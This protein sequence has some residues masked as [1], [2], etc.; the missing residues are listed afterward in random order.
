[1]RYMTKLPEIV[2]IEPDAAHK[3]S[4]IIKPL[5]MKKRCLIVTDEN[6]KKIAGNSVFESLTNYDASICVQNSTEKKEVENFSETM[7][8]YDFAIAVGG[9]KIIDITKYA[10]YLS[11]KPWI[12]FPTVFSHDGIVSSRVSLTHN[13]S[14]ISIKANGPVAVI[15]DYNIIKKAPTRWLSSGIADL[16][17]NITAVEDWRLADKAGKEELNQLCAGL[18]L[19]AAESVIK[20]KIRIM[21]KNENGLKTM[22]WALIFSGM[23]MNIYG[24]SRPASGSEHNFSHALE[25]LG[26]NGLHGE[27][28]GLG[29]IISSYL[30]KQDWKKMKN[31]LRSFNCPVNSKEIGIPAEKLVQALTLAPKIRDRYTV[32]NKYKIDEK[33]AREVLE[34]TEII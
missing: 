22:L 27:Q 12:S 33:F 24:T 31:S 2:T 23:S 26:S 11:K 3:I 15:A 18:S 8:N 5:N 19:T 6:I 10:C 21:E 13:N 30:Q 4:E 34:A 20:D 7:K 28:C 14:K 16:L 17:S 29:S 9:G 1:M 25:K 32:L